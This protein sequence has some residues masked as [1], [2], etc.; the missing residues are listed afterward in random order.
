VAFEPSSQ[1]R[2][3][4]AVPVHHHVDDAPPHER[5]E[6]VE[7]VLGY[8]VPEVAGPA[9]LDLV[10]PGEHC[11]EADLGLPVGQCSDLPLELADRLVRDERVDEPLVRSP[12]VHPLDAE[13]EEVEPFMH[14][15]HARLRFRQAQAQRGEDSGDLVAQ[16]LHV[17]AL[18]ADEDDKVV[19]LCRL[20]DYADRAVN[21]LVMDV[22]LAAGAA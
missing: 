13:A 17:T 19:R 20:R 3:G 11:V 4:Q 10:D 15:H 12:L 1:G 8:C 16:F 14:V 21:V 6:P 5:V 2:P 9:A 18:A 7:G 22:V